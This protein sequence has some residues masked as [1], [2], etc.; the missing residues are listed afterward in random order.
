MNITSL[1][2]PNCGN[3]LPKN[4][5]SS[6]PFKC[7]ACGSLLIMTPVEER[8]HPN[9]C[10]KCQTVNSP[11]Q[12]YCTRCNE[13]LTVDCPICYRTNPINAETCEGCGTNIQEEIL[14]RQAWHG[15]KKINDER[16]KAALAKAEQDEQKNEINR[17][18]ADLDEPSHHAFAIFSLCQIGSAAVEPLIE[19][20]HADLDPDA[21]YAAA[22]ALGLIA[23]PKAIPAI[24][25]A[26]TDPEPAVRYCAVEAL[27][28]LRA[29][30]AQAQIK[31]LLA[32][33]YQWVRERAQKT[34]DEL[35]GSS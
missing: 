25:A 6:Q 3:P 13:R 29:T 30:A 34:L 20:L 19:T 7:Q 21:R 15:L 12:R 17:L 22:R 14:R 35:D 2:C 33:K 23:D 8:G 11:F 27:A 28:P 26:L 1:N 31:K 10:V 5:I 9:V 18:L 4:A 24:T 16:R 32:D